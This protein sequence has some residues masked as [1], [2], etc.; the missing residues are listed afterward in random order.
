MTHFRYR[1]GGFWP[2]AVHR[3]GRFAKTIEEFPVA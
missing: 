2:V 3:L 1:L